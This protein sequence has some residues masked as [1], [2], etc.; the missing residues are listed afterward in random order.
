[1]EGFNRRILKGILECATL[2]GYSYNSL[3]PITT[4]K[5]I[6][7]RPYVLDIAT[8]CSI[9]RRENSIGDVNIEMGWR[10]I[11]LHHFDLLAFL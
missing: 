3:T 11:A 5:R 8:E 4:E 9:I 7:S 10:R 1:M 6:R 2:G